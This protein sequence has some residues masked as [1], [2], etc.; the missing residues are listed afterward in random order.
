MAEGG[1]KLVASRDDLKVGDIVFQT[2]DRNDGLTLTSDYAT[3]NKY[4]VIVGKNSKGDAIGL[5]LV[6]SNLDFYKDVPEMQKFQYILKQADYPAV[7]TK[8]SR[9]DCAV[10]FPMKARKSVAVKAR[11]VGHLTE[12]DEKV[13]LP[14]V[15]SCG[16]IDEHVRKVF[17]LN[18]YLQ[19]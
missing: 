19:P 6:N 1:A 13:V 2:L 10:L 3:R 9:L 14:L 18:T 8:D 15:A 12:T 7:L 16:F 11:V 5:C 4:F 17:R